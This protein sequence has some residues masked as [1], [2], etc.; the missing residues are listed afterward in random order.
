MEA[1]IPAFA[2]VRPRVVVASTGESRLLDEAVGE[3]IEEFPF[4][5]VRITGGIGSGKST[6]VAHLAAVFAHRDAIV[7]LDEPSADELEKD[8]AAS[9][10]VMAA[11]PG[12]GR[13]VELALEPWGQDQLIE[14]LLA[15]HH[16]SCGSVMRRLGTAA[17]ESWV[18]ELAC[19]V[20]DRFAA[21]ESLTEPQAAFE[22]QISEHLRKRSQRDAAAQFCLA[23]LVG[24]SRNVETATRQFAKSNC[25]PEVRRLLRHE[26][27][28]LPL[29]AERIIESLSRGDDKVLT[30]PFPVDLIQLVAERCR[31]SHANVLTRLS[32]LLASWRSKVPH[33]M[34]AS[35]LVAAG[36]AWRPQRRRGCW[37]FENGVFRNAQWSEVDLSRALVMN[38]DFSDA[39]LASAVLDYAAANRTRFIAANLQGA[40]LIGIQANNTSFRGASLERARASNASFCKANFVAA[41]MERIALMGADLSGADLSSANLRHADLTGARL[42]GAVL[43]DA[44][45]ES[46][47]MR[48][49]D[50][51]GLDLR[52]ANINGVCFDRANLKAVQLKDV[53][54]DRPS[55]C[56]TRLRGARLTGSIFKDAKLAGADLQGA[57]LAEIDWEGAN[58]HCANLRGATFHL[59]SSRSGLVGS[60]IAREGSMTGFYTDDLEDM[61]FKRPEEVR[62]ANLRGANLHGADTRNVDF[63]LVDLRDAGLDPGQREQAR[64]TG[65]IL[66]DFVSPR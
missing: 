64:Q 52:R 37:L 15:V 63:Y 55:M 7:F 34:A 27:V 42:V 38:C 13:G 56:D 58:L 57:E 12:V 60:P 62:K 10:V 65:A 11:L 47:T 32:K 26:M 4:F 3:L 23:Q 45:L 51:A 20:L 5:T 33:A 14:Y 43:E 54:I 16:D 17:S 41:Q 46:A 1:V 49:S 48:Q 35:I 22:R 19:I 28:Q 61:S 50:L 29:A 8:L 2:T 40:S 39:N 59:G 53:R 66:D 6:A 30:A 9:F 21:D 18:P 31:E 36:Q 25:P 44:D 24:G